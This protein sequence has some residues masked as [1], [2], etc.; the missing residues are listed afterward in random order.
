MEKV[1]VFFF[2]LYLFSSHFNCTKHYNLMH[3]ILFFFFFLTVFLVFKPCL[4]PAL[5]KDCEQIRV[6]VYHL[7]L[8]FSFELLLYMYVIF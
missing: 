8:Y 3:G 6:A 4:F 1:G 2:K 5:E 7:P